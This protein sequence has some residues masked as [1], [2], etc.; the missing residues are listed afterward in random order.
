MAMESII[1]D[2]GDAPEDGLSGDTERLFAALERYTNAE[3]LELMY[4]GEEPGFFEFIRGVFALTE[5]SRLIL[6]DFLTTVN[7][8]TMT[9]AIDPQGRCIL[10]PGNSSRSPHISSRNSL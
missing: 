5:E 4:V 6:H 7:P 10:S 2:P 9:A 1:C 3:L 8:R